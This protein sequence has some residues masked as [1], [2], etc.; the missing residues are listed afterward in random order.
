[1]RPRNPLYF[2]RLFTTLRQWFP[3]CSDVQT[4]WNNLVAA[5]DKILIFYG[6]SQT[7]LPKLVDHQWSREQTLGITS[8]RQPNTMKWI[9]G[10]SLEWGKVL[11]VEWIKSDMGVYFLINLRINPFSTSAY[12]YFPINSSFCA[13]LKIL[14]NSFF[15]IWVLEVIMLVSIFLWNQ[16][17][18]F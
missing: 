9:I 16:R 7:T 3:N 12:I 8:L 17:N 15:R 6:D 2:Q 18:C 1:L 4:T 11:I 10:F 5:K 13:L 14:L